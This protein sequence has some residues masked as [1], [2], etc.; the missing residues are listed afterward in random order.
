VA[1]I[2]KGE[3]IACDNPENLRRYVK[4]EKGYVFTL[5]E[6]FG[7]SEELISFLSEVSRL[8]DVKGSRLEPGPPPKVMVRVDK[9]FEISDLLE[10]VVKHGLRVKDLES[11]EP[12]LEEVFITLIRGERY[13]R[14]A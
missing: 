10:L 5:D 8:E 3:I 7:H 1:I 2:N 9:D 11:Y 6:D 12:S 4:P 13:E 14:E